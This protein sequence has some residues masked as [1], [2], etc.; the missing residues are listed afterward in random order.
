MTIIYRH[1]KG[2]PLTSEEIDGNFKELDGRL[3]TLEENKEEGE[4]LAKIQIE[5]DQISFRGTFGKD[6]GTFTLP[7]ATLN[8]CGSWCEQKPYRKLDLVTM[9]NAL[10]CCTEDHMS[11]SWSQ[12]HLRWKQVLSLPQGQPQPFSLPL[13]EKATLPETDSLGKM[14]LLLDNE[15]AIPLF[16]NGKNWQQLRKGKSL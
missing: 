15:E 8:L 7:K 2:A 14:A 1:E 6:F 11:I 9:H 3:K 5:G 10:Y 12:D 16:F 13:Y 4:G